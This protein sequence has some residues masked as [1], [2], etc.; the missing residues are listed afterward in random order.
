M[1]IEQELSHELVSVVGPQVR[2]GVECGLEVGGVVHYM[3]DVLHQ[4]RSHVRQLLHV[5]QI[6]LQPDT[7][8]PLRSVLST[9][10]QSSDDEYR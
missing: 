3:R 7:L 10:E 5:L 4:L 6:R 2:V 8:L 1:I 9:I